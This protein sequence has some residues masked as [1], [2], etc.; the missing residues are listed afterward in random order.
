MSA[1]EISA[2]HTH[3]GTPDAGR[4]PDERPQDLTLVSVS[5]DG[6]RMH[7]VDAAGH[8]FTVAV[9]DR[10]RAAFP[11]DS[12]RRSEPAV[13]DQSTPSLRPRDIQSRIRGGESAEEV[14]TAAGT[15]VEK[16]MTY[17]APVLA[18]RE[19]IAQRAQDASIRRRPG[20]SAGTVRLLGEATEAHLN[21]LLTEPDEV[22]WDS[23][24]R[25]DG[26]WKLSASFDLTQRSGIAEFTFDAPGN[27]VSLDNDD[28][29]WL[30]GE[31]IEDPVTSPAVD[32]LALARQRR[33]QPEPA[34]PATPEEDAD[35]SVSSTTE[36]TTEAT[37]QSSQDAASARSETAGEAYLFDAPVPDA[38]AAEE[39]PHPKPVK[40]RSRRK[41]A[42]VPSWDEIMFG[43]GKPE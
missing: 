38:G 31:I 2:P 11:V 20:E 19:H 10:L 41:R 32:D 16:I 40:K 22:A 18:E 3:S 8:E 5:R 34:A 30:V 29:R 28:A 15:T 6:Q 25:P 36:A 1:E 37:D 35:P 21:A 26:R 17:A 33:S 39:T 9:D 13:T 4:T 24:R 23:Y 7:F 12:S 27:Y 14:A 42:S 43:G